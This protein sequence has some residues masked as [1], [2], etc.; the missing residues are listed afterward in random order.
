MS[1]LKQLVEAIH[2]E[3]GNHSTPDVVWPM[4][5]DLAQTDPHAINE[6]TPVI[7][8]Y[9]AN[10]T[11]FTDGPQEAVSKAVEEFMTASDGA[12][13]K[14][15]A[16]PVI[17]W[18]P[19]LNNENMTKTINT[20]V[21]IIHEH[22]QKTNTL[23]TKFI[24]LL[25]VVNLEM[26][27]PDV[28]DKIF[29]TCKAAIGGDEKDGALIVL[30]SFIN[31][32][33]EAHCCCCGMDHDHDDDDCHDG[34]K[35]KHIMEFVLNT[36]RDCINSDD[37]KLIIAGCDLLG[38][39][40]AHFE[41]GDEDVPEP[42]EL[43]DLVF[44]KIQHSDLSVRKF[45]TRA[46]QELIYCHLFITPEIL[47]KFLAKF[48]S[49]TDEN[50]LYFYKILEV[51]I[52][53]DDDEMGEEEDMQ[54]GGDLEILQPIVDHVSEKLSSS[55][56]NYTKGLILR[57]ISELAYK[58]PMY[59][60]DLIETAIQTA[61]SLISGHVYPAYRFIGLFACS[62]S[63]HFD[64]Y[65]S[66]VLAFLPELTNS[67]IQNEQCGTIRHRLQGCG[68]IAQIVASGTCDSIIEPMTKFILETLNTN[69]D[70]NIEHACGVIV[71]MKTKLEKDSANQMFQLL[72]NHIIQTDDEENVSMWA[73]VLKK[74]LK[75]YPIDAN[76][77]DA[78]T[79]KI[80]TGDMVLLRGTTLNNLNSPNPLL[81]EYLCA[82]VT[83]FPSKAKPICETVLS[84]IDGA[85]YDALIGF[86][87][88]LKS[89]I[90]V[91]ALSKEGLSETSQKLL[92]ALEKGN[93]DDPEL[94]S[95]AIGVLSAIH[96]S[97][98]SAVHDLKA[99]M[100]KV[101]EFTSFI[102]LGEEE[103]DGMDEEKIEAMPA[104]IKFVFQVY[105]SNENIEINDE[106]LEKLVDLLPFPPQVSEMNDIVCSLAQMCQNPDRFETILVKSLQ[107]FAE[108]LL[109]K[110]SEFEEYKFTDD[111][112]TE[113]K[114]AL[115]SNVKGNKALEKQV[116]K[117]FAK[118]RAKLNRFLALIR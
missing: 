8:M 21:H 46:F 96:D 27:E 47:N 37:T 44:P 77:T 90:S 32:I 24:N 69:D 68:F 72:V 7:S 16:K 100:N 26:V 85:T 57:T 80:M 76:T 110:K 2:P 60:E 39:L 18:L 58:D 22:L 112:I 59:V 11:Q 106:L 40:S 62:V 89:G 65:L 104:I 74:L 84:W 107:N 10:E 33:L 43:F 13:Q 12:E 82:Y 14:S 78:F 4:L 108:L 101:N 36:V 53:P 56:S 3:Q 87:D 86:F 23:P 55:V 17:S 93:N 95:T 75:K 52:D 19:F 83:K 1:G 98:A 118:S 51:F 116:T 30:A 15:K 35:E 34:E 49:F 79:N 64:S 42:N 38:Q 97:D 25:D 61:E 114:Q 105:E 28:A 92:S 31:D 20:A 45:A 88:V 9:A 99:F 67:L 71:Q 48:P 111:T 73:H 63:K 41:H 117:E 94:F 113:M 91:G 103:D 115:K 54:D 6:I 102:S 5:L 109:M 81:F 29:E 70:V 66:S 50:V